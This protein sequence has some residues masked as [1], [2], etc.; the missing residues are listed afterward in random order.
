MQ[1]HLL[2]VFLVGRES[3]EVTIIRD[4]LH[5]LCH[6]QGLLFPTLSHFFMD[7]VVVLQAIHSCVVG[8]YVFGKRRIDVGVNEIEFQSLDQLIECGCEQCAED[9]TN[10]VDPVVMREVACDDG[11]LV[12]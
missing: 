3:S 9:R 4:T 11:G 12:D 10:P 5:K 8:L 2:A 1:L 7:T 6:A